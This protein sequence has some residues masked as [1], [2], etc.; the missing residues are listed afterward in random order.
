METLAVMQAD[1]GGL[2]AHAWFDVIVQKCAELG[3]DPRNEGESL[4]TMSQKLMGFPVQ[5]VCDLDWGDF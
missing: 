2:Q 3:F 4:Y 5:R 1:G